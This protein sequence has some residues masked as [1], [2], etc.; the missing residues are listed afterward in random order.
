MDYLQS[1]ACY[2]IGQHSTKWLCVYYLY[3]LVAL[4]GVNNVCF[5]HMHFVRYTKCKP[6]MHTKPEPSKMLNANIQNLHIYMYARPWVY[7]WP[8]PWIVIKYLGL[9]T[10]RW[11][12]RLDTSL[13]TSRLTTITL[14]AWQYQQVPRNM[15]KIA[16]KHTH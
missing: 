10:E 14:P 4:T 6:Q 1:R 12:G 9:G 8:K 2:F 3:H 15:L 11:P 13:P 16:Q 7:V 5:V